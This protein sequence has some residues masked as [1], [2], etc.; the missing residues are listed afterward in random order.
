MAPPGAWWFAPDGWV[1][2][3]SMEPGD[4]MVSAGGGKEDVPKQ[5]AA[6]RRQDQFSDKA[7]KEKKGW[8]LGDAGN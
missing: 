7:G 4:R 6:T 8:W 2:G 1:G 3:L 5:S